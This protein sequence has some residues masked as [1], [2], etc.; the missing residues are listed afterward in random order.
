MTATNRSCFQGLVVVRN[1]AVQ[2]HKDKSD[3]KKV[4]LGILQEVSL[5]P[6]LKMKSIPAGGCFFF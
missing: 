5:V 2:P 1:L 4:A 6:V 3:Y